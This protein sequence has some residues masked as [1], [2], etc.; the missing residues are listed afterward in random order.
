M[1]KIT[2]ILTGKKKSSFKNKNRLLIKSKPIFA[3]PAKAAKKCKKINNFTNFQ[4]FI[5]QPSLSVEVEQL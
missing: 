2:A 4:K 1:V 5:S 3:Y